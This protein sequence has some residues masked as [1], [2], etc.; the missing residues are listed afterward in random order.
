[1]KTIPHQLKLWTRGIS[2]LIW[3]LKIDLINCITM[4]RLLGTR[5]TVLE[6]SLLGMRLVLSRILLP[7]GRV[8]IVSQCLV[9]VLIIK[10]LEVG[11]M[12]GSIS[13]L[14]QESNQPKY[15]RLTKYSRLNLNL[16]RLNKK[17]HPGMIILVWIL[18]KQRIL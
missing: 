7:E 1:M 12:V 15:C 17:I 16:S 5:L 2:K 3:C 6:R 11:R 10:C 4:H 14:Y 9:F 13:T 8:V 18:A